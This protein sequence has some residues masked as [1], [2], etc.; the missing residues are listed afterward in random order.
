VRAVEAFETV[1]KEVEEVTGIKSHMG[2]LQM[3]CRNGGPAPP[4]VATL[5][6][7][8]ILSGRLIWKTI[9]MG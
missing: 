6:L 1:A 8:N 2:K 7:P 5:I 3:W 4:E 9:L